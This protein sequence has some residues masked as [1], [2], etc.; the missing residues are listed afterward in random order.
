M[1]PHGD[2]QAW[3]EAAQHGDHGAYAQIVETYKQPV[4]N[5]AYRMLGSA[6]EAEDAAQEVFLRAYLKLASYDRARRFSTWLLSICSNYCID[7]LRRRRG[8]AVTL[9]DA[10]PMLPSHEP[11]PEQSA[12]ATEQREVIARAIDSLPPAY[13]LPTVLR[14]YY[15]LP[16]DEIQ[17]ITGL[18]E[19]TVKTRLHRARN[20]I[21]SYLEREG[22]VPWSAE[23]SDRS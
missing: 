19:E 12:I 5:L 7:V 21:K 14:Y 2:E 8:V 20:M 4:F 3:I 16:Y 9:E 18:T 17:H 13:R 22:A 1:E 11:G 23:T 10:E 15:D 6:A